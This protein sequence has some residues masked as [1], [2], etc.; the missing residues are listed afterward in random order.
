[1]EKEEQSTT[2]GSSEQQT[3]ESVVS[4]QHDGMAVTQEL[5]AEGGSE[6]GESSEESEEGNGRWAG[7]ANEEGKGGELDEG[8]E[9]EEGSDKHEE[10]EERREGSDEHKEEERKEEEKREDSDKYEGE[11]RREETGEGELRWEEHTTVSMVQV[12]YTASQ[13]DDES[14]KQVWGDKTDD[15]LVQQGRDIEGSQ[16]EQL[17]KEQLNTAQVQEDVQEVLANLDQRSQTDEQL[18]FSQEK[19]EDG[20]TVSGEAAATSRGVPE[21][22]QQWRN[23]E[24]A[25]MQQGGEPL[26]TPVH[27]EKENERER[28]V[29]GQDVEAFNNGDGENR[30]LHAGEE[31]R[32]EGH[33]Q[34]PGQ[35]REV[36][37]TSQD[38]LRSNDDGGGG[39]DEEREREEIVKEGEQEKMEN[40]DLSQDSGQTPLPP[41]YSQLTHTDDTLL[42]TPSTTY[43]PPPEVP[44]TSQSA[45]H[46][47]TASSSHFQEF[48]GFSDDLEPD[49][50]ENEDEEDEDEEGD[51]DEVKDEDVEVRSLV[52][53]SGKH[54]K[55]LFTRN[56]LVK[57]VEEGMDGYYL[58]L[59]SSRNGFN[60]EDIDD[61]FED[62]IHLIGKEPD[63]ADHKE[64]GSTLDIHT[65]LPSSIRLS[66]SPEVGG[67]GHYPS[68]GDYLNVDV[69]RQRMLRDHQ[70]HSTKPPSTEQSPTDQSQPLPPTDQAQLPPTYH[71]QLPFTE[72]DHPPPTDQAQPSPPTD[73]AQP[74]PPTDQAQPSPPTD[75]AQPSPPTDQ[76]Q[77]S[78]PTDQAQPSPPTD[79]AQ[80]HVPPTYH[81]QLPFTD[82][83]QPL[84]TDQARPPPTDQAQPSPPTDQAQPLPT[85]QTQPLPTDQ[86]QPSPT[87]QAQPP[88]ADQARPP[89][90]DHIQ[91]TTTD[92]THPPPTDHTHPPPDEHAEH[93]ATMTTGYDQAGFTFEAQD[94]TTEL[95]HTP[96]PSITPSVE[97]SDTFSETPM[98]RE[99]LPGFVDTKNTG[100]TQVEA[101]FPPSSPPPTQPS[102]QELPSEGNDPQVLEVQEEDS[103]PAPLHPPHYGGDQ[104]ERMEEEQQEQR[105]DEIEATNME[106]RTEEHV[107]LH[108]EEEKE[109]ED[110]IPEPRELKHL[111]G[112]SCCGCKCVAF[113]GT[114]LCQKGGTLQMFY[115]AADS[116]EDYYLHVMVQFLPEPFRDWIL[117]QVGNYNSASHVILSVVPVG[118]SVGW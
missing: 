83:D 86:T 58:N 102:V 94:S 99:G 92:D 79:Q 103:V 100:D 75:Q 38:Y 45:T 10:R 23:E 44:P 36:T 49:E 73:Q 54:A 89:P 70:M 29:Q 37:G 51:E 101:D 1:M 9:E 97:I 13:D 35:E 57:V 113:R 2:L 88:P 39:V 24:Q 95:Q 17:N 26:P 110:V 111:R 30:D 64:Q 104:Q 118:S 117:V 78:P 90:T 56:G 14:S 105:R 115:F 72:Q 108:H 74:S 34:S 107:T 69:I 87:D 12:Q 106:W 31:W 8:K 59:K 60:A 53:K 84:P 55:V 65:H 66:P 46:T 47:V 61:M 40:R 11:E 21:H 41:L 18:P 19:R 71:T 63:P 68:P 85:D 27:S 81:T 109:R 62:V 42:P 4:E 7:E 32:Q 116:S 6:G 114:C 67:S 15:P 91:P 33:E 28:T 20:T 50:E 76:A 22:I 98:D 5:K 43:T 52:T 16:V 3:H 77:P 112:R 96:T 48:D 25:R 82:Q 93:I 80:L